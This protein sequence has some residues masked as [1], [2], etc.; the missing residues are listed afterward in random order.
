[1][2][3][4]AGVV[5]ALLALSVGGLLAR[6]LSPW[7]GAVHW[8][9]TIGIVALGLGA[10]IAIAFGSVV[11]R[12]AV[13]LAVLAG[14]AT[15]TGA[16]ALDIDL[17][18]YEVWQSRGYTA[19]LTLV[20]IATAIGLAR[21]TPWARWLMIAFGAGG[22]VC[23]AI[24]LTSWIGAWYIYLR[25][26]W[27]APGTW[28]HVFLTLGSLLMILV[29]AGQTMRDA[30]GKPFSAEDPSTVWRA[31]N[32]LVTAV[33]W[34]LTT[35]FVS[36]AM[37]LL[38]SWGQPVVPATAAS[39][40]SLAIVFAVAAL[41]TL[42]RKTAGV[43]LLLV[44]GAGFLVQ[45]AITV[46]LATEGDVLHVAGYYAVFWTAAGVSALVCAVTLAPRLRAR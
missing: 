22:V 17:L 34:T 23:G 43:L 35:Q 10:A 18:G 37:S 9:L 38:Y 40:L 1:M 29:M 28:A 46:H 2:R 32:P 27:L 4:I 44:T 16:R 26:D 3:R 41:L 14:T 30:F 21:R 15:L 6:L 24:N 8:A 19:V 7:A 11:G 25:E 13:G 12:I 31:K 36:A 5:T 20:T 45:A 33:R 42:A 39:A